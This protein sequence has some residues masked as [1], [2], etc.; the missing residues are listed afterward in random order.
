MS[1]N[2]SEYYFTKPEQVQS[3]VS[4]TQK[5]ENRYIQRS[6][7]LPSWLTDQLIEIDPLRQYRQYSAM[8]MKTILFSYILDT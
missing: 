4:H 1:F 2:G 3:V 6:N 5:S 8:T 7:K